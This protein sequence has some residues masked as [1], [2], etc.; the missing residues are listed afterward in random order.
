L[1]NLKKVEDEKMKQ[2]TVILNSVEYVA[3][4]EIYHKSF[5]ACYGCSAS[6]SNDLC[7]QMPNCTG[8]IWVDKR[9]LNENK[10]G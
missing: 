10:G 4:P 1:K 8:I 7:N 5:Y 3:K 9:A 2:K 6:Y